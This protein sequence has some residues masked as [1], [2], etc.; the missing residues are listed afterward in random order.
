MAH[1]PGWHL[2]D[3]EFPASNAG[4]QLPTRILAQ[5]NARLAIQNLDRTDPP[6]YVPGGVPREESFNANLF[7]LTT[8]PCM[9][10]IPV[11]CAVSGFDPGSTPILWRFV[12]RQALC[13]HTNVGSFRYRGACE[14]FEQE[15]RGES[16][17]ASFTLFDEGCTYTYNDATRVIGGHALL[18]VAAMVG[19]QTLRDFVHVR[20]AG[21]NPTREDVLRYV[22]QRL[23]GY[24]RS[25]LHMVRAIYAHESNFTQ[26][27]PR[28]QR[29]AAMTF[30]RPHHRNAVEQPDCRVHFDW[31]DDPPNFPLASFDFGVGISQFTKVGDQRVT[32]ELAWDWR[33]NVRV[34]TN[35]FLSKLNGQFQQGI[36]W[37]HWALAGWRAYNGSGAAAESY[38]QRLSMSD[39]AAHIPL[40]PVHGVPQVAL[41]GG[42]EPLD[43]PAPWAAA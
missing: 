26:F 6:G 25:V 22:E 12:C 7:R 40:T 21:T 30:G 34:G 13:R 28:A 9:P 5:G 29:S 14:T 19:G 36:S 41:L 43:A 3:N 16:R 31:P 18:V 10:S 42:P 17:A 15:W 32:A 24:D 20:I 37:R 33:E 1:T 38:A 35:L 8:K 11:T 4:L 27:A 2:L 23:A 39:E